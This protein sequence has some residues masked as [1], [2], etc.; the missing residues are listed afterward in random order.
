MIKQV[1]ITKIMI[2]NL[3][4]VIMIQIEMIKIMIAC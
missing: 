4:I 2:S 1:E 3:L